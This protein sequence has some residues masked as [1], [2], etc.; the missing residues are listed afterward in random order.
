MKNA[1]AAVVEEDS[2][3][4]VVY[5]ES[6]KGDLKTKTRYEFR[7]VLFIMNRERL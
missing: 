5:S 7:C 2:N 4:S 1:A 3:G 6:F